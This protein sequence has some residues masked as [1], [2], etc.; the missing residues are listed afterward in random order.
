MRKS[1]ILFPLCLLFLVGCKGWKE[2]QLKPNNTESIKEGFAKVDSV[3]VVGIDPGNAVLGNEAFWKGVFI[4]GRKLKL[5]RYAVSKY[6]VTYKLWKQVYDWA[7][8]NG[9][10]FANDG[11]KGGSAPYDESLHTEND[12][13]TMISFRDAI[14]WCNAYTQM[15]R[16]SDVECVYFKSE[17]DKKVLK[18]ATN[19]S[20]CDGVYF[21]TSKSGFR[22]PTEA[23]WEW[24]ARYQGNVEKNAQ[25]YGDIYLT[26]LDSASGA[27]ASCNDK[28]ETGKVAWTI[29]NADNHTHEVGKKKANHLGI[30]DMSGNVCEWCFDIYEDITIDTGALGAKTGDDRVFRGGQ[31]AVG[32]EDSSVGIRSTD[33]ADYVLPALGFRVV[34]SLK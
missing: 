32:T 17:T 25:K 15:E 30:Y 5:N 14:V 33:K 23:E 18:D 3:E 34:Y 1:L 4:K 16:K 26:N 11:K 8:K 21:D 7:V 2:E 19:A 13:V 28:A 29:E 9:Y 24:A 10:S 20:E 12:P 31:Y 22:L 27:I 6:E